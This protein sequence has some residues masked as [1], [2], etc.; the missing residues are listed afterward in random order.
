M[1]LDTL[2]PE[3][4]AWLKSQVQQGHFASYEDAID[5]TVK[6]TS[7]RETLHAAMFDPR[8]YDV[9]QVRANVK[10]YIAERARETRGS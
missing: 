1:N 2:S 10:T 4:Q 6:L 8:R 7:L 3:A 5:Y 9:E